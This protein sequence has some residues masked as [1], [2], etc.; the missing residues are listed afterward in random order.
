[1][2]IH[3]LSV[4]FARPDG[5]VDVVKDV[6]LHIAR[7]ETLGLL[8]ESGAGKTTTALAVLALVPPPGRVAAASIK[9][10][11]VELAGMPPAGLRHVRGRHVGFVA[12]LPHASLNPS[13]SIGHQIA[14]PLRWHLHHTRR[15]TT[16][17]VA[18]LLDLVGIA[19]GRSHDYPHQLSGGEAQRVCIAMALACQPDVLIADEPTT[20]LD[21]VT[22]A[23]VLE[24]L[25]DLGNTL[26][27][28]V[29]LIS[30]DMG[31]VARSTDRVA[32]MHA[33]RII[34]TQ[35]TAR[36]FAQPTEPYTQLLIDSAKHRGGTH[37]ES[38]LSITSAPVIASTR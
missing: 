7:G 25:R 23:G 37:T 6:S 38:G 30:H 18:E 32:V 4:R 8:G 17:D 35:D 24:L 26:D 31:V 12:Q 36:L 33:G 21:A 14:E 11:G 27:L 19:S 29:L 20:A 16:T 15:Q 34:E 22:Q 5:V 13:Y 2:D 1:L 28:G 10:S 9:V 3:G